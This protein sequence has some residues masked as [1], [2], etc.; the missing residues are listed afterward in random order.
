M[1]EKFLMYKLTPLVNL[2]PCKGEVLKPPF[3]CREGGRGVRFLEI[4]GFI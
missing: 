3:L 1:F 4:M 2:S